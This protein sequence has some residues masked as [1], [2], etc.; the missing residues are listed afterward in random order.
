MNEDNTKSLIAS[1][2]KLL[3]GNFHFE[4]GDGWHLLLFVAA[5]QLEALDEDLKA[6]QVKE[7]FGTLRFYL[8]HY[9]IAA[10]E[11]I[12]EAE[13]RSAVT[14][15]RCG[16]FGKLRKGSWLRTLCDECHE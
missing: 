16:G 2:P 5:R 4:C 6:V 9:T 10:E 11:I 15:E 13:R 8:D 12:K 7:K 3:G 14:C 1:A